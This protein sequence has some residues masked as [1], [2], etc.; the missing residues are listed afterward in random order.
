M[1]LFVLFCCNLLIFFSEISKRHQERWKQ[2]V[3]IMYKLDHP[4]VVKALIVPKALE[5]G[6]HSG[7]YYT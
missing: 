6:P 2:E 1:I 5:I 3:E 7:T 4:N